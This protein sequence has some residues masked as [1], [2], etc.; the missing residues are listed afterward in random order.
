MG[1]SL[2]EALLLLVCRG[3]PQEAKPK[4]REWSHRKLDEIELHLSEL[5]YVGLI[6]RYP[7]KEQFAT[8][9]NGIQEKQADTKKYSPANRGKRINL[10]NAP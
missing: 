5:P 9:C 1:F 4:M 2:E 8:P 3:N 10:R 7:H 6:S